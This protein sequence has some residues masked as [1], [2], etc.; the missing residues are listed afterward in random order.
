MPNGRAADCRS[1]ATCDDAMS[2]VGSE[3]AARAEARHLAEKLEAGEA[4]AAR[5]R[6]EAR[7]LRK[8]LGAALDPRFERWALLPAFSHGFVRSTG[9]GRRG[10][11]TLLGGGNDSARSRPGCRR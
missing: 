2:S 8:G 3:R 6:D 11:R 7:S 5:W 9:V 1:S 4:E 10:A